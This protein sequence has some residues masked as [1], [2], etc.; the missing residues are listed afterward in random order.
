LISENTYVIIGKAL[1][2]RTKV[3]DSPPLK[4][5]TIP[6]AASSKPLLVPA[7][8]RR[9]VHRR[10]KSVW[11][12][13]LQELL[14]FR[15]AQGHIHVPRHWPE[16]PKLANWVSNQRRLIR[17]N[18]IP[19]SRLRRLAALGIAW[20]GAAEQ[21]R[22]QE[23]V[24]E[25]LYG[26]LRAYR[27]SSGNLQVPRGWPVEPRLAGWL[28]TQRHQWRTG[29]LSESRAAQLRAIDPEWHRG[30][31]R[32]RSAPK[33]RRRLHARGAAWERR[34]QALKKYRDANGTCAIPARW[35][36]DRTLAMW[37][38]RQRA[39]RKRGALPEERLQRLDALGFLWY[40]A[41][42]KR[43]MEEARWVQRFDQLAAYVAA[44]G[45]GSVG[46]DDSEWPG[47]AAWVFRQ[48]NERRRGRLR[49]DRIRRL[50]TLN[51]AWNPRRPGQ[52]RSR[53]WER[54]F[55]KLMAFRLERGSAEIPAD[56]SG[57]ALRQW[58]DGQ[59]RRQRAGRLAPDLVRRLEQAGVCWNNLDRRWEAGYRELLAHRQ[60][61]GDCKVDMT[62]KENRRLARWV[63]AQRTARKSGRLS[64]ARILRLE[65]L[66]FLWS[67]ASRPR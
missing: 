66:G 34:Y 42:P 5:P 44:H 48:R 51:F 18:Q 61:Q 10:S 64:E 2:T 28:A 11:E 21:R 62:G 19:P 26:A 9:G 41:D 37:V 23:E 38:V 45:H 60:R 43:S 6:A 14:S 16:N 15:K 53:H 20:E 46:L 33:P 50:E 57:R 27:R 56:G 22:D 36:G 8:G 40:G 59:R 55:E 25:R 63:S 17:E 32:E 1:M 12:R 29:T 52:S 31:L 7:P 13:R 54:M 4:T 39:L 35:N 58:L 65:A 3:P 49:D 67:A 47:L 24:W 30:P